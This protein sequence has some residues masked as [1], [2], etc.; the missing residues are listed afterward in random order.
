MAD[1]KTLGGGKILRF[2]A[3]GD[4]GDVPG[5]EAQGGGDGEI[6]GV[7]Q[8]HQAIIHFGYQESY[9]KLTLR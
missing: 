5:Y 9:R 2:T 3:G 6:K 4:Q 1:D 7:H 8:Q